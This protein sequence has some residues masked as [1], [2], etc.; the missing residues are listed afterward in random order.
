MRFSLTVWLL[1]LLA[2][3][4]AAAALS[5]QDAVNVVSQQGFLNSG[6]SA[7]ITPAVKITH[8]SVQYWVVSIISN[9]S[10]IGFAALNA[11]S[12]SESPEFSES[13]AVN[14]QLFKTAYFMQ[15]F[16]ASSNALKQQ[17]QWFFTQE[18]NGFFTTLSRLLQ[19]ETESDLA[20]ISSESESKISGKAEAMVAALDSIISLSDSIVQKTSLEISSEA[21]FFQ[22]PSSQKASSLLSNA[23]AVGQDID[24]LEQKTIEYSGLVSDLKKEIADSNLDIQKKTA[25]S[26]LAEAPSVLSASTIFAKK[27]SA[28]ASIQAVQKAYNNAVSSSTGFAE[29]FQ[30]RLEKSQAF[31]ELYSEDKAL[32]EKTKAYSTLEAAAE[33]ILSASKK[34][35]WESQPE[36]SKLAQYWSAAES[37]FNKGNYSLAIE[38]AKKAKSSAIL[39]V[40]AGFQE[41]EQPYDTGV[42]VQA[43]ILLAVILVLL[44]IIRKVLPLLN[45][46]RGE[47]FQGLQEEFKIKR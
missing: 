45:K 33:D 26:K 41:Q 25:L 7:I 19:S 3:P 23:Q 29:A 13:G 11:S 17:G 42:F 30:A 4:L 24:S 18:N 8:S 35:L 20:I 34:S 32:L 39:I 6:E 43:A 27:Q 14:E 21:D 1:L 31:V 12:T 40:K 2:I 15:G 10:T 47:G 44:V 36:V 22:N 16:L 5:S 28:N 9:N 46:P 38:Q 37:A